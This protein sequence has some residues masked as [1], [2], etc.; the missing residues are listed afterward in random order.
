MKRKTTHQAARLSVAVAGSLV[1]QAEQSLPVQFTIEQDP[2]LSGWEMQGSYN[3]D[4]DEFRGEWRPNGGDRGTGSMIIRKGVLRTPP[5]AV[6]PDQFLRLRFSARTESGG[7]YA[8][9]FMTAQGDESKGGDDYNDFPGGGDWTN[10]EFLTQVRHDSVRLRVSFMAGTE[11]VEIGNLAI[12]PISPGEALAWSDRFC[13]A[14]PPVG[15]IPPPDRW[16]HLPR[17]REKL[18]SGDELTLLLLG[19]SVAND[20]GNAQPHLLIQ[21]FYPKAR[22]RLVRSVRSATGAWHFQHQVADWVVPHRPD[23]VILA[24]ISHRGDAQ[25]VRRLIER[26]RQALGLKVEFLV[27][28]GAVADPGSLYPPKKDRPASVTPE[29]RREG[30]AWEAAYLRR[31]EAMADEVGFATFDMR[32]AWEAYVAESGRE[33]EWF[34]RDNT[35]ANVR[36]KQVLA[37]LLARFF[38]PEFP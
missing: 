32:Q 20:M 11:V 28:T 19:D 2:S 14:L 33:R 16:R 30:L 7:F 37:R 24:G 38:E 12:E 15:W 36:G 4:G 17:T 9:Q 8:I 10:H 35:H 27:L 34:M 18:L 29:M 31:L 21:R 25:A 22:V 5:I 23:L 3:G 26:T 13:A 6:Q 1:V